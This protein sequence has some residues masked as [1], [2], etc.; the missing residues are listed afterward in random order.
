MKKLILLFFLCF[1][2]T[3]SRA[4]L[5]SLEKIINYKCCVCGGPVTQADILITQAFDNNT[6]YICKKCREEKEKG[7]EGELAAVIA[8]ASVDCTSRGPEVAYPELDCSPEISCEL[9]AKYK[10]DPKYRRKILLWSS[11]LEDYLESQQRGSSLSSSSLGKHMECMLKGHKLEMERG[12]DKVLIHT[13]DGKRFSRE[14]TPGR[15]I[16]MV[17]FDELRTLFITDDQR[18]LSF[19]LES[20]FQKFTSLT[21]EDERELSR[22][23]EAV[24][25]YKDIEHFDTHIAP[26]EK[27][28]KFWKR[29]RQ[30]VYEKLKRPRE[31]V[32]PARTS[33]P[34]P[35]L[36]PRN[37]N[38]LSDYEVPQCGRPDVAPVKYYAGIPL[39]TVPIQG[40]EYYHVPAEGAEDA[41][42]LLQET[43]TRIVGGRK[44]TLV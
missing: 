17:P 20:G 41:A 22:Q 25:A 35:E 27:W 30:P 28:W 38:Q 6:I 19:S 13:P 29:S 15:I 16:E 43:K 36:P 34:G 26:Q 42:L 9:C 3:Y 33:R 2:G 5:L 39:A 8:G 32:P 14:I 18:V 37:Q 12:Q 31:P 21:I 4:P 23:Q 44:V 24:C 1:T 7:K 10:F 40:R 11:T